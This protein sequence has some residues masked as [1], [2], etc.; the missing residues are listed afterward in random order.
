MPPATRVVYNL[1]DFNIRIDGQ[2]VALLPQTHFAD[3]DTVLAACAP[4]VQAWQIMI[5]TEVN[6]ID[7]ELSFMQIEWMDRAP[8]SGVAE[9]RLDSI[10]TGTATM[11]A[12]SIRP[13]RRHPN[14]PDPALRVT[15]NMNSL[16]Q[17]Y[18]GYKRGTEPL[19]SMAYFVLTVV[20]ALAAQTQ[21][22]GTR[23]KALAVAA[24]VFN[25]EEAVLKKIGELSST[26]GDRSTARKVGA[27]QPER[28]L[29]SEE[30][31]WLEQA[32][33]KLILQ[34]GRTNGVP[35][36]NSL[37]LADLPSL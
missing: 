15:P 36:P 16:W 24:R 9:A 1:P 5:A 17:R 37:R 12:M 4:L 26:R 19:L 34:V 31:V 11:H 18:C 20:E 22:D 33:Q 10:A 35:S 30:C 23:F 2:H 21:A 8:S 32:V 27:N 14:A 29:M 28:P 6:S 7:V 13:F 25:V 3:S